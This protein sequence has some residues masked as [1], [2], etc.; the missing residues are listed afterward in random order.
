MSAIDRIFLLNK[1][2]VWRLIRAHTHTHI[3]THTHTRT[4]IIYTIEISFLSHMWKRRGW[5]SRLSAARGRALIIKTPSS[6]CS[7]VYV[8]VSV[9][10]DL[11]VEFL[12]L[13]LTNKPVQSQ[14][15]RI[16]RIDYTCSKRVV[17]ISKES[18]ENLSRFQESSQRLSRDGQIKY[19]HWQWIS[20]ESKMLLNRHL[21]KIVNGIQ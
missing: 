20:Q 5:N 4:H 10:V 7:C 14:C 16:K 1:K 2:N 13:Y 18:R 19:Q 15:F 8:C 6:V 9:C 11:T 3:H 12:R 17:Q 21:N